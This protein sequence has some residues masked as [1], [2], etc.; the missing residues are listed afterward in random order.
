MPYGVAFGP[1][2]MGHRYLASW[3][4]CSLVEMRPQSAPCVALAITYRVVAG[5]RRDMLATTNAM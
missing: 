1:V 5:R 3:K 4:G 2:V